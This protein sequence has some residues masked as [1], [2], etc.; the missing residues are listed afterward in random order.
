[1]DWITACDI[2]EVSPDATDAQIKERRN[3]WSF[4]LAPDATVGKPE[5]IR[6]KAET[7][8]IKKKTA[9]EYLLI[10]KNRPTDRSCGRAQEPL[11]ERSS[12]KPQN[13][14]SS[15]PKAKP[16]LSITPK[17]IRFKDL[18]NLETKTTY[19]EINNIG[20]PF[21]HFSVLRDHIPKWLEITG[22]RRL[23]H[24]ELPVQVHIR[25]TGQQVGF[26]YECQIPVSI[27][28]K[29]CGYSDEGR[30]HIE[31]IMKESV[32]QVD[33][34]T[35]QFS[36][37]PGVIPPPQTVILTNAG[38]GFIEGD[39]VPR[40][41]WIKIGTRHIRF[42]NSY[43]IQV[44]VD[45]SKL[46]TENIGFIDINTNG[47]YDNIMVKV[48]LLSQPIKTKQTKKLDDITVAHKCAKD[49]VWYNPRLQ[50]YECRVCL[51]RSKHLNNIIK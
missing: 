35:V 18:G 34:K 30:V 5:H 2:I 21:T 37:T 26:K 22:I 49:T 27:E 9:W 7:E 40:Q 1:M 12:A 23:S 10:P 16:I 8:Y 11:R 24:Q 28:N 43:T 51:R 31:L 41:P 14:S 46:S 4:L 33:K 45:T 32:V 29:D 3:Y 20:G 13:E 36:I 48:M 42:Q 19:F 39:L 17:H 50:V 6:K 38:T 25:A 47:G 15:I 44:Q